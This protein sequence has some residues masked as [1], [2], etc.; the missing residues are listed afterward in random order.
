MRDRVFIEMVVSVYQQNYI[1]HFTVPLV[2]RK[3]L[4][5]VA[6]AVKSC[7]APSRLEIS[8]RLIINHRVAR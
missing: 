1:P 6:R 3:Y 8:C 5:R 7:Y 4:S 2:S